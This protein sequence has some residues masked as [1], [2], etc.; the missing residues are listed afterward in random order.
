MSEKSISPWPRI[1][2]GV[3][4]YHVAFTLGVHNFL[5][6]IVSIHFNYE[7]QTRCIQIRVYFRSASWISITKSIKVHAIKMEKKFCGISFFAISLVIENE[8]IQLPCILSYELT[9][10][11]NVRISRQ[12]FNFI[13]YKYVE[14]LE[15][16]S[17]DTQTI[18][19]LK[20]L[21]FALEYPWKFIILWCNKYRKRKQQT[22]WKCV[23]W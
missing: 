15:C 7:R 5:C 9:A 13:C 21:S 16:L 17:A 12:I 2:F 10:G 22:T 18:R 19:W 14:L 6:E 4:F 20:S 11:S 3:S 23:F 8:A 1:H